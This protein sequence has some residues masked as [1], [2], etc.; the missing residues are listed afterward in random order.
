MNN[1]LCH[2]AAYCKSTAIRTCTEKW[3]SFRNILPVHAF[4]IEHSRNLLKGQHKIHITADCLSACLQLLGST[5]SHKNNLAV[6]LFLLN[7]S[8]GQNHR[9][10]GH[11]DAFRLLREKLLRHHRPGRAAGCCHKWKFLRNFFQE[12][13]GLL[14]RTEI[15]S[16]RYFS[17]IRKSKCLKSA[18][19]LCVFQTFK[20]T[21]DCRCKDCINRRLTLECHD[22]L[23][24][25]SLIN[26]RTEWTAYETLSAGYTFVLVD[27]SSSILIRTDGI[28]STGFCTRT[29]LLDDCI[30]WTGFYTFP[31]LDAQ[32]LINMRMSIFHVH[33]FLRTDLNTWMFQTALASFCDHY[34]LFRT[35]ITCKLDH[36]DKRRLII[37]LFDH[38]RLHTL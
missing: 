3:F 4:R 33:G 18:T 5:R 32:G 25:L 8:R 31:T 1:C 20:L 22:R 23:E 36:I 28:H 16:D 9:S 10:Q 29:F 2:S 14:D 27:L 37:F 38:T 7:Q 19:D 11:G 6:R 34:L 13:L 21:C 26:D 24:Y 35:G 15:R 17:D 12:I 30:I